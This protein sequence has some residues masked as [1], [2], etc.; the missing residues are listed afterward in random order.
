MPT[1]APVPPQAADVPSNAA[2]Y[3]TKLSGCVALQ[4]SSPGSSTG[5]G[6]QA[7]PVGVQDSP[8]LHGSVRQRSGA[9]QVAPTTPDAQAQLKESTPSVQEPPFWQGFG[10]HSSMSVAQ[11]APV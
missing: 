9:A 11:V 1:L 8:L 2:E 3:G 6:V 10:V 4:M 7:K 5:K